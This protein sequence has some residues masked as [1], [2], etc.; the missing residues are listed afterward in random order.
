MSTLTVRLSALTTDMTDGELLKWIVAAGDEVTE[1]DPIAEFTTDK[2]DTELESPYTG[3]VVE[4]LVEESAIVNVGDAIATIQS[5]EDDLLGGLDLGDAEAPESPEEPAQAD[6]PD[7]DASSATDTSGLALIPAPPPVRK[8]ARR[9]GIDLGDVNPT[10]SRG[11]VTHADLDAYQATSSAGGS[12]SPDEQAT[13]QE[14]PAQPTATT[15]SA[16]MPQA[17]ADSR[18]QAR[19]RRVRAATAASTSR[20]QAIPQFTL[21][22]SADVTETAGRRSGIGWTTILARSYAAMLWRH[23]ELNAIWDEERGVV[24]PLDEVR[25]G[26]AVDTPTGLV[27]VALD[28]PDK[29]GPASADADLRAAAERARAGDIRREDLEGVSATISNLG[30]WNVER[31]TALL[32][33]PQASILSVGAIAEQPSVVDGRVKPRLKMELGLTVD[34]RVA[35]GADAARALQTLIEILEDA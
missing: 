7:D 12:S 17:E 13:S 1:G 2:V 27:V 34:H 30:G 24:A 18:D 23:P 35:D 22:R 6:Q 33:P 29:Q 16:A 4:L 25:I 15:P 5:D 14:S 3:T 8:R 32:V 20:S 9:E 19:R 28:D 26:L 10:G 31:F 11:Q 21:F